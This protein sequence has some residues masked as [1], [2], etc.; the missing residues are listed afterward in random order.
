MFVVS[1]LSRLRS[2][3]ATLSA[4]L[5]SPE[6]L[7]DADGA[8]VVIP[9]QPKLKFVRPFARKAASSVIRGSMGVK[10]GFDIVGRVEDIL[11][12]D[13]EVPFIK[14]VITIGSVSVDSA[15]SYY[16]MNCGIAAPPLADVKR[17]KV[18]IR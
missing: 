15:I 17:K 4:A 1:S 8:V 11:V 5:S 2:K 14:P 6:Y 12:E 9:E 7:N 3:I 10:S 13:K 18:M 16:E